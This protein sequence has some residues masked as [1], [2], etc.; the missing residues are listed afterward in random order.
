[1]GSRAHRRQPT[2]DRLYDRLLPNKYDPPS[3]A[4]RTEGHLARHRPGPRAR[5]TDAACQYGI[6]RD[7]GGTQPGRSWEYRDS[8]SPMLLQVEVDP[9]RIQE[10]FDRDPPHD[11]GS[12]RG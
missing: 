1:M 12:K 9:R 8:R 3:F 2:F 6:R 4:T 11:G 7:E 5:R 10:V